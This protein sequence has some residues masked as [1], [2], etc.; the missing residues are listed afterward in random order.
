MKIEFDRFAK[1]FINALPNI[2]LALFLFFSIKAIWGSDNIM[3]AFIMPS[4][5]KS[6][7]NKKINIK[8]FLK[9][10]F[11]FTALGILSTISTFNSFNTIILNVLVPFSI[12]IFL[13]DKYNHNKYLLYGL[14]YTLF[15]MYP[16]DLDKLYIRVIV[17]IYAFIVVFIATYI[18]S[19]RIKENP[20][21]SIIKLGLIQI[22]SQFEAIY[23]DE[24]YKSNKNPLVDT[25]KKL[26]LLLYENFKNKNYTA[27]SKDL[28]YHEFAI[29]F[30]HINQLIVY[31]KKL[32]NLD[33][34]SKKYF[35]NLSGLI[36]NIE[37]KDNYKS[38]ETF[39]KNNELRDDVLDKESKYILRSLFFLIKRE[40]EENENYSID[41]SAKKD[42]FNNISF[43]I[44]ST[45]VRFGIRLSIV[46]LISGIIVNLINPYVP[47][48]YWLLL[49]SYL[50]ILPFYEDSTTRILQ[51]MKG[52]VFGL[53]G[54]Y[55][56]FHIIS[57]TQFSVILFTIIGIIGMNM[58]KVY[59]IKA[60]VLT[61]F[62]LFLSSGVINSYELIFL[63]LA[64][65]LL[66][67]I[68]VYLGN[69][70]ILP[71]GNYEELLK[72]LK[73]LINLDKIILNEIY[74]SICESKDVE[75]CTLNTYLLEANM[76]S[77]SIEAHERSQKKYGSRDIS[78]SFL[79]YNQKLLLEFLKMVKAI[80][81]S[82][83]KDTNYFK[84][85]I[86]QVENYL[87]EIYYLVDK[88]YDNYDIDSNISI[89]DD[90]LYMNKN[91]INSIEK[92]YEINALIYNNKK[93]R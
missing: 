12:V 92:I 18:S 62:S 73:E 77:R 10:T 1:T 83:F 14:V 61:S 20:I 56:A 89:I 37:N 82:E 7:R 2:L 93:G 23:I 75:E 91:L 9:N 43:S 68:L 48:A 3:L 11:I 16:I 57:Y 41:T 79:I 84:D 39:M 50:M 54:F 29:I 78:Q 52:T 70:F 13:S 42:K 31:I 76:I 4:Y 6:I 65:V 22:T 87:T 66:A 28:Y 55:I 64:L 74:K 88:Y 80:S 58:T 38:F 26:S 46:M 63:R 30:K 40:N 5:F 27:N 51:R 67:A 47:K 59:Y 33:D 35:F 86:L 85:A 15:Q 69:K 90:N 49:N 34:I 24:N 19:L 32:P 17:F 25:E 53:I 81:N 21:T 8:R 45:K 72:R 71:T 60:G 36:R 44:E